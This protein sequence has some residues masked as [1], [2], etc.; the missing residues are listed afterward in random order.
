MVPRSATISPF[1]FATLLAP[2]A[3]IVTFPPGPGA[4][5]SSNER[6][7]E[8]FDKLIAT[9][10][11][12]RLVMAMLPPRALRRRGRFETESFDETSMREFTATESSEV[13]LT[14]PP[15]PFAEDV[16]GK[17]PVVASIGELTR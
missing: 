13:R 15:L 11:G 6:S 2:V 7:S 4:A 1:M 12:L 9:P 8:V 16:T 17:Y 14:L 3:K 5:A 10:A